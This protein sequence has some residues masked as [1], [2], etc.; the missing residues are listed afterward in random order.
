METT[1]DEE[2][3]NSPTYWFALMESAKNRHDFIQAQQALEELRRLGV[4]ITFH[5]PGKPPR[6]KRRGGPEHAA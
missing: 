3:R 4:E 6:R 5:K 1:T 2:I